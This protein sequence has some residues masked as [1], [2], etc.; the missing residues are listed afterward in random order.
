MSPAGSQAGAYYCAV[1]PNG[2][3]KVLNN[4]EECEESE[5]MFLGRAD[6]PSAPAMY[7][8]GFDEEAFLGWGRVPEFLW[9]FVFL[10]LFSLGFRPGFLSPWPYFR[11]CVSVA[12]FLSPE[13]SLQARLHGPSQVISRGK[14][15]TQ[16]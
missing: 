1:D 6:L 13:T 12:G 7:G 9:V 2:L 15:P 8:K 3:S 5:R 11:F 16:C 4:A 10:L 14:R